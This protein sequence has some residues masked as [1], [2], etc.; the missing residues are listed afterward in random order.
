[1]SEWYVDTPAKP[2][3]TVILA[4]GAGAGAESEFMVDMAAQLAARNIN[5]VR[6]NFPYMEIIK[7]SLLTLA[8]ILAAAIAVILESPFIKFSC[9][10]CHKLNG[11]LPST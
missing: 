8:N 6:F 7:E 2:V 4:H 3:A 5:V 1:M 9:F 11:R 10:P